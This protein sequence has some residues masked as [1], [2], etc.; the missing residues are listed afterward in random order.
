MPLT[1]NNSNP[2][3]GHQRFLV[4]FMNFRWEIRLF[5]QYLKVQHAILQPHFYLQSLHR[6]STD[7]RGI[8]ESQPRE[9]EH[10]RIA[11]DRSFQKYAHW[12]L[13]RFYEYRTSFVCRCIRA[14]FD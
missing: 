8:C 4:D 10:L 1:S 14:A 2:Q 11:V 9:Y 6:T 12:E 5:I 13:P 3:K 7:F